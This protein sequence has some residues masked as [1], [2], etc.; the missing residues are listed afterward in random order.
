[1]EANTWK[2]GD[3]PGPQ[4]FP[5]KAFHGMMRAKNEIIAATDRAI[6]AGGEQEGVLAC[7]LMRLPPT[8]GVAVTVVLWVTVTV[9][10]EASGTARGTE[11]VLLGLPVGNDSP[12]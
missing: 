5:S 3:Q 7:P 11:P 1:M 8:P 2:A 6:M 4:R 12:G 9:A 10:T